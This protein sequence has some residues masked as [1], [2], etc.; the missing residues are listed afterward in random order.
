VIHGEHTQLLVQV[1]KVIAIFKEAHPVCEAL[2]IFDQS[3]AH[4][5]L[6]PDALHT[7]NMNNQMGES[8]EN[9]RL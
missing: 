7:F 6:R 1:D 9:K 3:S 8:R 2:F 4:A 5:L